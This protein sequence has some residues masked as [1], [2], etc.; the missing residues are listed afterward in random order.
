M[1]STR[2]ADHHVSAILGKL[3][4]HSRNEAAAAARTL[5]VTYA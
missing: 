1:I 3:G 2:P 5:G 4:V